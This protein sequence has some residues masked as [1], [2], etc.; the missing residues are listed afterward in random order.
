MTE[1]R[2]YA[3][4]SDIDGYIVFDRKDRA[5][6]RGP[7]ALRVAAERYARELETADYVE[8]SKVYEINAR[9]AETAE[10]SRRHR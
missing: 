9:D 7:F 1:G 5:M 4:L 3:V 10:L 8:R 6:M 2:R